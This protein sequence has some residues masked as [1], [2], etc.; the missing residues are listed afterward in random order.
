M[1]RRRSPPPPRRHTQRGRLAG[2]KGKRNTACRP[3]PARMPTPLPEGTGAFCRQ[4]HTHARARSLAQTHAPRPPPRQTH[5]HA[6]ARARDT[7]PRNALCSG[8]SPDLNYLGR[9]FPTRRQG[10]CS[11]PTPFARVNPPPPEP[12]DNGFGAPNTWPRLHLGAFLATHDCPRERERG[13]GRKLSA[14]P[15][16]QWCHVQGIFVLSA[17]PR[18]SSSRSSARGSWWR[19]W[20]W[21]REGTGV[22]QRKH[23]LGMGRVEFQVFYAPA[24]QAPPPPPPRGMHQKRG[25]AVEQRILSCHMAPGTQAIRREER[26]GGGGLEPKSLRTKN[27]PNQYFLL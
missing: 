17:S 24:L 21:V 16:F 26:G 5:V 19:G 10:V 27:S 9:L 11:P 7:C 14:P 13:I 3:V 18:G 22:G 20:G 15:P 6:H 4:A 25:G 1:G 23:R 8:M 12:Q 2:A